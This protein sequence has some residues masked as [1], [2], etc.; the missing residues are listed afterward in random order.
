MGELFNRLREQLNNFYSNLSKKMKILIGVGILLFLT[1]I[2]VIV[3]ATTRVEYLPL[4]S[5]LTYEEAGNITAS[6]TELGI[7]WKTEGD[8]SVVMVPKEQLSSAK[9]QLSLTGTLNKKDFSWTDAFSKSSMTMTN[10]ERNAMYMLAKANTLKEAIM[11]LDGID[12]ATVVL[13]IPETSPYLIND[14]SESKASVVLTLKKGTSLSQNQVNGIENILVTSVKGLTGENVTITD[15]KG[16]QLNVN[17][18]DDET[19]DANSQYELKSKIESRLNDKLNEFL[20]NLYGKSNVKVTTNVKLNFDSEDTTMVQFSPPVEGETTGLVRSLNEISE[21][22]VNDGNGGAPGT[23]SNSDITNYVQLDGDG[24]GYKKASRTLNYE[25]NQINTAMSK[26]KGQIED[27]SVAIILNRE[28]LVNNELTEEHKLELKNLV[29]ASAGLE[30][31]VVEVTAMDFADPMEDFNVIASGMEAGQ[32]F[33]YIYIVIG[34]VVLLVGAGVFMFLS[35]RRR[36]RAEEEARNLEI[37]EKKELEEIQ[38]DFED[39]S[40]PKYQIEKFIETNPEAVAA[41]LRTWINEE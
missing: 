22:I 9:M 7:E 32:S 24:S 29:S 40:S 21:N 19:F 27:I 16:V 4:A 20:S 23:D 35:R 28:K 2:G 15:N 18:K 13:Y 14:E 37:Q 8:S 34:L 41:L 5:G 33:P 36:S 1:I 10:E 3:F 39:K 26:A 6:L 25:L 12:D 30:T 11:S 17:R 38:A 31:K